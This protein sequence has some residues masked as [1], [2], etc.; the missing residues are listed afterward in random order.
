MSVWISTRWTAMQDCP[1][2]E[3]ANS[4]M[5]EAAAGR[6]GQSSFTMTAASPPSS[7]V[8]CLF[9]AWR[10]IDQPTGPEPVK[11][12]TGRRGSVTSE[13][14]MSFGTGSTE[15]IRGGR[16]VSAM[17]SPSSSAVSGV[18]GAGL[19]RMGAPTAIAG[20]TLCATRFSGKLNGAMPRTGP[21]GK[22]RTTASRP[23]AGASV[24]SR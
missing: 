8:M 20:A 1:A 15:T 2:W 11:E 16:S 19:T 14:I 4:A 6:S 22:R 5:R 18:A 21:R 12:M 10:W 13:D 3:L 9:G 24:S 23:V 7:R 17:I